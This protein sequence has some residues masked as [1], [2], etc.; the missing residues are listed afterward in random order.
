MAPLLQPRKTPVTTIDYSAK[1]PIPPVSKL[2]ELKVACPNSVFF[3][4]INKLDPEDT[5]SAS[6]DED[7]ICTLLAL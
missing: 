7:E 2:Q 4:M 1:E 3:D 6:E 5:D